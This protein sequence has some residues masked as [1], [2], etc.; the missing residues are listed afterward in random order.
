MNHLYHYLIPPNNYI[1][2]EII[3]GYI[4]INP[5]VKKNLLQNLDSEYFFLESHRLIYTHLQKIYD[6]NNINLKNL[7]NIINKNSKVNNITSLKNIIKLIKQGQVFN[8]SQN[9]TFY[10]NQLLKLVHENYIKRLFIQYS[11]NTINLCYNYEKSISKIYIQASFYL[12]EINKKLEQKN[13]DNSH[14][15]LSELFQDLTSD[16]NNIKNSEIIIKSGFKHL[17]GITTGLPPGDLIII[18]GRP[19][20]GKTSFIINIAYN[21]LK[22]F[23]TQ[24]CIF[25]LEM[26]RK[27]IL[28]KIISVGSTIPLHLIL[29]GE[30]NSKE[31]NIIVKICQNILTSKIYIN[32]TTNISIENILNTSQKICQEINKKTIIFID[33]LQL[34]N[35]QY[36][37]FFNRNEELSY[38]TRKL[39][40]TAQLLKIPVIVLSQL[41]RRIETRINKKPLL[42]DLKESGC[43]SYKL[44][45]STN[46]KHK[47]NTI[48]NNQL[49]IYINSYINYY[50]KNNYLFDYLKYTK[51]SIKT[52]KLFIEYIFSYKIYNQRQL[53]LTENHPILKYNTWIKTRYLEENHHIIQYKIITNTAYKRIKKSHISI[54]FAYHSL[55]YE[56]SKKEYCNFNYQKIIL[57]NSIEQDADIIIMLYPN[58]SYNEPENLLKRII[59]INILKNRNGI[60]GSLQL[61]FNL[62]STKF[63]DKMN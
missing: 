9:T 6:K 54:L 17:D 5:Y 24:I 57:H 44:F 53:K 63:K 55:V 52:I 29:Q 3:I 23:D 16:K 20:T 11:Y 18:A 25:S 37:I 33:Y 26:T 56:I 13:L 15:F 39:K 36:S 8:T 27:Q 59:D 38:I 51:N 61:L 21:I 14:F 48:F 49:N 28:Q 1:A 34:I 60:T 62:S 31:W 2:E 50:I 10:L 40:I 7:F 19:S 35:S 42:S 32:D 45:I 43:I 58:N 22:Q 41:N 30:I 12:N 47:I 4:I 46:N